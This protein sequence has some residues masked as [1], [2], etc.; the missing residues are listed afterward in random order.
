MSS[1]TF[2][3]RF[4]LCFLF[5]L[6]V[7]CTYLATPHLHSKRKRTQT[8]TDTHTH[9]H[10][11]IKEAEFL[12]R[13]V[14]YVDSCWAE[15]KGNNKSGQQKQTNK[16]TNEQTNEHK[17]K[18]LNKVLFRIFTPFTGEASGDERMASDIS[19]STTYSH[20]EYWVIS[21]CFTDYVEYFCGESLFLIFR[22]EMKILMEKSVGERR[23]EKESFFL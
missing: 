9:T 19:S 4:V 3:A 6:F 18:K 2:V 8:N 1:V 13:D 7:F 15:T 5:F 17:H 14:I 16:R 21:D 10:T 20:G 23:T 22:Y 11:H 12:L